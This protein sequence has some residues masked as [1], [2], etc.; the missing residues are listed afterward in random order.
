MPDRYYQFSQQN[1]SFFALDT[2]AQMYSD[3]DLQRQE[4]AQWIADSQSEWKIAFGHHPYKSNGPHGNA[5]SYDRLPDFIP[6]RGDNIQSFAEDIWCGQVDLYLSGHDHSRQ[7][8]DVDCDGTA[9]VV[10]GAGAKLSG[11]PGDNPYLYQYS[12]YGFLYISITG[13]TLLAQF[14]DADG[15]INFTHTID[16][17]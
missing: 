17:S 7:W 15:K 6:L 10:S 1:I 16:K 3:D 11:L 9:L 5:G 4:V 8:L 2:T 12:N 13:T 14:I